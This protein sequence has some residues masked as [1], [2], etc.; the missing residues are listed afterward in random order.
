LEFQLQSFLNQAARALYEVQF[1]R[2]REAHASERDAQLEKQTHQLFLLH[3]ISTLSQTIPDLEKISH[4]ILTAI[5]AHF[6]LGFNRAWLFLIDR[7]TNCLVGRM[8][9]GS[10]TEEQTYQAWDRSTPLSFEDYVARLLKDQIEHDEIDQPTRKLSLPIS[11]NSNDLF[12]MTVYQQHKFQWSGAPGHWHALPA[13]F[14]QRFEPGDM[15]LTPLVI[16]NSCLGLIAVDSKFRPRPFTETDELLLKTFA[17]QMATAI[18]NNQQHEQEKQRL[19]L[20]ETLRDTSLIIGSSLE[21]KEV[22]PRILEEMRKVLPFDTASIQLAHEESRSLKIIANTGFDDPARVE[23]LEFPLEGD[24]P[25][26]LVFRKKEPLHF[27]DVQNRFPH[28]ADP[29]YQAT[30]VHG[31]LGAP[32]IIN[33]EAIGVI[34]LDSKIAG[35]YTPEHDRMAALFAGQASVAIE[36]ARLFQTEKETNDYLDLL[37]G[38]SQDGIIAVDNH[39]WVVRFSEGAQKILGYSP[40][41]VLNQQKRV[42]ALYG[43]I[44][45]ARDINAMLMALDKVRD[46]QATIVDKNHNVIPIVLSASLLRDKQGNPLGSVGFFKDLRPLRKVEN[47][48]RM[49]LDTVSIMSKVDYSEAGLFA[50]AERIVNAQPVTF[51]SILLLDE[52]K[53]NLVVKVAYPNPR[54]LSTGVKWK[55]A[56]GERIPL[57]QAGLMIHLAN[58]PEPYVFQEGQAIEGRNVIRHLQQ[59]VLLDEEIRSILIVPL[60]AGSEAFGIC[61]LGETRAWSRSPFDEDKVELISSL[62]T[63]GTV[64]VDRLQAH[65]A[66]QNKLMMVERLR[67]IGEDLVTAAPGASKSILDKVVRA[68]CEVTGASSAIIYPWD[69]QRRTYDTDKI[70]HFGLHK[71]KSFSKKVR[72]EEGSMTSIVV[73][74][75]MV[76]VDDIREGI[77]RSKE[78]RIWARKGGLLEVE[79]VRAFVGVSL[80]I[81]EDALGG[82]F[83]NF[84]EPHYF[85][86]SELEAVNLFANQA[87]IAVEN[88]R[89][90]EDLAL[91]LEESTALQKVG[92]SLTGNR[93]LNLVLDR[94]LQAAFELIHAD[95][96][97]IIFYDVGK[98]EFRLDALMSG[99]VGLPLQPYRSRIRQR[100]GYTYEII[101]SKKH[102]SIPDTMLDPRINP[103]TLRKGRRAAVGVP[104]I[105][106]ESPVGVLWMHWKTPHQISE[107]DERLLTALAGQAAISIENA[108]LFDQLKAEN[109]RKY[110]ESR[111]LQE[112]GIS[113]TE[114]IDEN[115]VLNRVFQ[116][117][118]ELV[119]AEEGSILFYDEARNEFQTEALMCAGIG[120]PLEPY[121]TQVRQRTGL[122]YDI[123]QGRKPII[124]QDTTV[125]PRIS[126]VAINKGRRA[127]VGVPLLDHEG[128]VG[129]LWVNWKTTR[130]VS[131]S[132]ASLLTAL[133]SQA[134]V[135]IKGARRYADI[136]KYT[137]FQNGLLKASLG[138]INLKEAR[139][140]LQSITENI[141]TTFDCDVVTLYTYDQE[142]GQVDFPAYVCGGLISPEGLGDLGRVSKESVVMKIVELGQPYFA[143][144]STQD[145]VMVSELY[146][147][148]KGILPF[149]PRER[150]LSSAGIPLIVTDKTVGILFVNY[151]TYHPFSDQEQN[152]IMLYA[153]QAATVIQLARTYEAIQRRSAH[154]QAVH[155]AGKVISAASVGLDQQQVL[156]RILEQAIECV[157]GVT[158]SK[159]SVGTIQMLEE[160]TNELV[161]KSVFPGQYPQLSIDKFDHISLNPKKPHNGK[162]GVTGRAALTRQAQLVP[163]VSKDEDYIVHNND[164]K[165]ELAIPMLD[166]GTVVGVMDVESNELNAFDELDKVSL[167]LL[168]DLA[169]VALRNAE[170][171]DQLARSNAV[172]L[173]GAW[174]AEIV[175]GVN[176]EVGHIRREVFLLGRH[177]ALPDEVRQ[178]LGVIDEFAKQLALPEIPERIPGS[179]SA[180]A[181]VSALLDSTIHTAVQIYRSDYPSISFQFKPGCSGIQVA[182]HERFIRTIFQNLLRNA[183]YALT[184][185]NPIKKK[186]KI[187]SHVEGPMAMIEM[188]NS[189]P[190]FRPEIVP[191]LFKRLIPHEDGRKGRGLLLV[192]FLVE[193]HGGRI[194]AVQN[195]AKNGVL[196]RF[197]LPL[198]RPVD[199]TPEA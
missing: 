118:L 194:E 69:T 179:E 35:I 23:A 96:A 83:V 120:Q 31:W 57:A 32:L 127:T 115:G 136:Q 169:V 62:V 73:R 93:D 142:T 183:V 164:T 18:F 2:K 193:Q 124:I 133:A 178:G 170:Q 53:K 166:N 80:R 91:R 24:Y 84:L 140:V 151:R 45:I 138:I 51:C 175:H 158:G 41:E 37:I 135:A 125:D 99:G 188:E 70:V 86:D 174:G 79:G 121:T 106:R 46:Y 159:A 65:E 30:H 103:E 146:E 196:F 109:A 143:D 122:A 78:T 161:V 71:K 7:K 195:K 63:Q 128:P 87:A 10:F 94:V 145:R 119:D 72:H 181:P 9:I 187:R 13:E 15:I 134:T 43:S 167:G 197:W 60:K 5:T 95:E 27:E 123:I 185:G 137:R 47:N 177:P 75:G 117:A 160:E 110:E 81:G 139:D 131:S 88:A 104:L 152:A 149:V 92:T 42:D 116:A 176:R 97:N 68:A 180:T 113:L 112:I 100:N 14:K 129:V 144:H 59:Y 102:I 157:T 150:I 148:Q 189:G 3:R 54:P 173:M 89:L 49:I 16:Q 132:E 155:E 153:A 163:D 114:T 90:Y 154:L 36:N 44:E 192:G 82:L 25:N 130:Q 56:V 19:K 101:K 105:G 98:D 162:I 141:K 168:V 76:I 74:K 34:T 33:K 6:G 39:G 182:M 64:F 52:S 20:E 191:F 199:N 77:D 58:L 186:I 67:S 108:N 156:D 50:L 29:H 12:S 126:K 85:S 40:E 17:N 8:G 26:V 28:F 111:A 147:R 184:Q 107:R 48:L 22:L 61:I 21:L 165:S 172:G 66:T 190:G 198:F 1:R 55:P 38:S 171:A 11:E 4:L